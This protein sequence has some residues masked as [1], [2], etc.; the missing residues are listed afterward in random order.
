MRYA[1][2]ATVALLAGDSFGQEPDTATQWA[3]IRKATDACHQLYSDSKLAPLLGKVPIPD[4]AA[5]TDA[6][7]QLNRKPNAAELNALRAYG[8]TKVQCKRLSAGAFEQMGSEGQDI[9][10]KIDKEKPD[11]DT[12]L[13]TEGK[14][15]F[16]DYD[17]RV[18]DGRDR[19]DAAWKQSQD[20]AKAQVAERQ[21]RDVEAWHAQALATCASDTECTN[22]ANR[23]RDH[24]V[25][26]IRGDQQGCDAK[27]QDQA[28]IDRWNESKRNQASMAQTIL[29]TC[30]VTVPGH[31][32]TEPVLQVDLKN[33]K[34]NGIDA[35]ITDAQFGWTDR[36]FRYFVNRYSGGLQIVSQDGALSLSGQCR[37]AT[38]KQF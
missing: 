35:T 1:W 36:G 33:S 3:L 19:A 11:A 22:T 14:L 5:V 32:Q 38:Q 8:A 21:R 26:C 7:L 31:G 30:T 13:L 25:A 27:A 24:A 6:M 18:K 16:A 37:T 17:A 10:A 23:Y 9:A 15:T 34:V 20:D 29:L 2:L 12:I 28:A 4:D